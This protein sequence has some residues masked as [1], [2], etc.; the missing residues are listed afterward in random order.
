MVL[1]CDYKERAFTVLREKNRSFA[2]LLK[3]S[4]MATKLVHQQHVL[5]P[6][7]AGL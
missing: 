1:P 4:R 6:G 5:S 3:F 7:E 2:F